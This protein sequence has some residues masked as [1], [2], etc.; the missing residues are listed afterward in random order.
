MSVWERDS[1]NHLVKKES[2]F[3]SSQVSSLEV[4]NGPNRLLLILPPVQAE[5]TLRE[6]FLPLVANRPSCIV[7]P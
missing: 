2:K 3:D 6:Y 4:M 1:T 5:K 7:L